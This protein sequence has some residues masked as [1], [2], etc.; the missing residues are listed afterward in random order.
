M[1]GQIRLHGRR[2]IYTN[3]REITRENLLKVLNRAMGIHGKNRAE[4]EYL[5]RYRRGDTPVWNRIKDV[6]PEIRHT[7]TENHANE[8]VTFWNGYTYGY[9]M[10]YVRS[11]GE[12]ALEEPMSLLNKYMR[13]L[14]KSTLDLQRGEWEFECG[15]SYYLVL[16]EASNTGVPFRIYV[17][18]PRENG[19]VYSSRL[20]NAR[21]LSFRVSMNDEGRKVISGYTQTHF[22]EVESGDI[23]T[24]EPHS[25]GTVP[26]FEYSS[27]TLKMG[28][29]EGVIS[30]LD[31]I[32][33]LQSNRG[34]DIDQIVQSYMKLIGC[35]IDQQQLEEFR[36]EKLIALPPGGDC[37]T[38]SAP[39][40]QSGV[41]TYKDDLYQSI[42][43]TCSMPNRN[44]GSS[45][46]DTGAAV[47]YRDGW[48]A[49]EMR[50][51]LNDG[52]IDKS[53]YEML[54]LVCYIMR[55]SDGVEIYPSDI[56]I[57]HTRRNQSSLLTGVQA[58]CELLNN[59]KVNPKTA[60]EIAN[61]T[62][63]IETAYEEGMKW[64]EREE[65]SGAEGNQMQGED[66]IQGREH[67]TM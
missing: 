31:E 36:R 43:L 3:E 11:S 6:R 41:Q 26:V 62:T 30:A 10:Q 48:T 1:T 12:E 45:T 39:L 21:M 35:T 24:W 47:M 67:T 13:V 38:I 22:Y 33:L 29:F 23:I 27:S 20:G 63:D 65:S 64:F 57:K 34:D 59:E 9:P 37:D 4:I 52:M 16:P 61:L 17:L 5:H 18:D 60:W 32:D 42:L 53:E 7:V 8:I 40:N 2:T 55:L 28:V 58:L 51:A 49:A 19:V 46:S 14:G 25:L 54:G 50:A 56:I 44:G 66:N 15:V